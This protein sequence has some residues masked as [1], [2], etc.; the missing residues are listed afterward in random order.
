MVNWSSFCTETHVFLFF[1]ITNKSFFSFSSS[2]TEAASILISKLLFF[3]KEFFCAK[4]LKNHSVIF[5]AEDQLLSFFSDFS[6]KDL[7]LNQYIKIS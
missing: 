2:H 4:Y 7:S 3:S 5:S 1:T 6:S